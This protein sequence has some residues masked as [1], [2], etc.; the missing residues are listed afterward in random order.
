MTTNDVQRVVSLLPAATEIVCALGCESR[1]VGRSHE[2]D[3][4][5]WVARLPA[6]TAPNIDADGSSADIDERMRQARATGLPAYRVIVETLAKLEPD[7]I[8]TQ[9][10]CEVCAVSLDEVRRVLAALPEPRPRIV[11]LQAAGLAD[12]WKDIASVADALNARHEAAALIAQLKERMSAI[13]TTTRALPV[14]P[15]VACIEWIQPLMAAGNWMPELVK[16]AGGHPLFV[17]PGM[18]SLRLDW[19]TLRAQDPEVLLLM[20][21]GFDIARSRRD[22]PVLQELP[23]WSALQAVRNRRVYLCDGNQYFNRPGPRLLASLEIL[24]EILHPQLFHFD[25]QGRGWETL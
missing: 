14:T 24:A 13:A 12:F 17:Q 11:T 23:G 16:L 18:H 6:C 2:C 7:L 25:H 22:L 15:G 20:P 3:H 9:V 10:Q 5:P 8:V 1:L 21:C 4:P 19:E